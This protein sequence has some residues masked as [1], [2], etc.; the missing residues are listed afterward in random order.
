MKIKWKITIYFILPVIIICILLMLFNLY[1]VQRIEQK[2]VDSNL[3]SFSEKCSEKLNGKLNEA[4][5]LTKT[6]AFYMENNPSLSSKQIYKFLLNNLNLNPFIYGSAICFLPYHYNKNIRFFVRYVYRDKNSLIKVNPANSGYDYTAK[7][8]DYWHIPKNTGKAIWTT[9]YFD[10]GGGNILMSTYS[11]PFFKGKSFLGI[12][13]VDIPLEPLKKLV[14]L[15]M[16][17]H[18][19]LYLLTQNGEYIYSPY[20][21]HINK[22]YKELNKPY[23]KDQIRSIIESTKQDRNNILRLKEPITGSVDLVSCTSLKSNGWILLISCPE[24]KAY[25]L[26]RR[27]FYNNLILLCFLLAA[28]IIGLFWI[29]TRISSPIIN[30]TKAIKSFSNGDLNIKTNF[31][32]KDEIGELASSFNKMGNELQTRNLIIQESEALLSTLIETI[33]DLVWLKNSDGVYISCNAKFERFFGATKSK[34]IGKTDYDFLSNKLANF[35][36]EKDRA[37]IAAGKPVINEENI[38]YADDG[39]SEQIETIKT[40]MY[41]SKGKLLGVLGIARDITERKI[42]EKQLKKTST[43]LDTAH[44]HAMYMLAVASEYK[45]PETG[46]HIKRIVKMTTELALEMGINSNSAEQM[47]RD[48]LLHDLGKIGISDYILLKPGKLTTNEF[49]LMKQHV[50]IGAKII[51]ENKWFTQAHQIAMSHH[52]RWDG[53]GY[54]QGLKGEDIPI[55]ARI[56]SVADVFDALISKRPYKDLWALEKA[57]D[58]IEQGSEAHFDPKVVKALLSLYKKGQLKKYLTL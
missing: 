17:K 7:K 14:D 44:K 25:L 42:I 19:S 3:S 5:L 33:P 13:T 30:L 22:S 16:P 32:S 12:A 48:S 15:N 29:S 57:I 45:D 35:F 53:N 37:A 11:V 10:E 18:F 21:E 51:G 52:E 38:T 27:Q 58:K 9:P 46:D 47:G 34:I 24:S 55:A 20:A 40:P 39:H 41:D 4:A 26:A 43:E 31:S 6:T 49:E 54:P 36:R 1:K 23:E 28:I 56:V 50:S 8:Q 2:N